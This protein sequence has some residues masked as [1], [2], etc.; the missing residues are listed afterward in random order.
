MKRGL[1]WSEK[2]CEGKANCKVLKGREEGRYR[3][4][5]GTLG[6]SHMNNGREL[7][8]ILEGAQQF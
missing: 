5:K 3:C 8:E 6:P 1:S 2:V 4:Q 7:M